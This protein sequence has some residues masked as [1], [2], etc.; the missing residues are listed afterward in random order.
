MECYCYLRDIQDLLSD[1][2]TLCERRFGE[3]CE[4]P[5]VPF[6][7]MV[8]SHPASAQDLSPLHQFGKKVFP[9]FFLGYVLHAAGIW[10]GDILVADTKELEKLG[11][12]E[13]HARRLNAKAV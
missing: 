4:G 8:E 1:G 5:I 13:L 7:A 10:K 12:S 9:G 6:G 3:L 2:K 11:A